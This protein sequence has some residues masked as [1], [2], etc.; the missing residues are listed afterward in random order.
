MGGLT[1]QLR[2][3]KLAASESGGC[4]VKVLAIGLALALALGAAAHADDEADVSGKWIGPK[5]EALHDQWPKDEAGWP[6]YGDVVLDCATDA[7]GVAAD[8]RV[9]SSKPKD[10]RLEQAAL[11]L[12]KLYRARDKSSGRSRLVIGVTTDTHA[13]WLKKPTVREMML[14]WPHG[15]AAVGKGGW[16]MVKCT[17]NKQ[18]LLQNCS[19][20][21]ESQPPHGFGEAALRLTPTFLFKPAT[22]HGEPIETEITIPVNFPT[23]TT[24]LL[25]NTLV[26]PAPSWAKTPTAQQILA[27]LDKK[28]GD[29]FADGKIVFM[30]NLNKRTGKVS[31]CILA[32]ESAGMTEF[33]GV[34]WSLTDAFEADPKAMA[35][36]RARLDPDRTDAVIFLPFSFPDMTS[37]VWNGRH[38]THVQWTRLLAPTPDRP[39][40]P[41]AALKAGLKTGSASVDCLIAD[42]GGL[43]DCKV[44][45]ESAPNLGFG[46]M[47]KTIAEASAINP[48]TDEGLPAGGARVQLPIPMAYAT[49]AGPAPA[50]KP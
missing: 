29:K 12:A 41:D 49:T 46:D 26:L 40:F 21:K 31:H 6:I 18:G 14:A 5:F 48:W 3:V 20:V 38:L 11:S 13:D 2:V 16:G 22:R 37:P 32:N 45:K 15:A 4:S 39:L 23:E 1:V 34:A 25:P 17:V 27:Q 7:S 19:V 10:P 33:R 43:S 36:I 47:A 24:I 42:D 30:C 44:V 8:C 50:A 35:D 9:T 28:V